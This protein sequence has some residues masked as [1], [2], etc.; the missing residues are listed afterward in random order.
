[1]YWKD[2]YPNYKK[3]YPDEEITPEVLETLRKSD[4]QLQRFDYDIKRKKPIY[5]NELTGAPA[6]HG[7]PGAILVDFK[8]GRE[9][10]LDVLL[11]SSEKPFDYA[12]NEY[13]DPLNVIL[14]KER[15]DELYRCLALLNNEERRLIDALFFVGMTET[16]YA[17]LI[18]RRQSSVNERKKAILKKIRKNYWNQT[19]NLPVSTP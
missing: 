7:D 4:R 2:Y 10:S 5:R 19:D 15:N 16:E 17:H 12:V 1:M 3:M 8:P 14:A 18:G 6:K 9:V 13:A 11:E